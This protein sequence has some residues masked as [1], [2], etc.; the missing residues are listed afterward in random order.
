VTI[1]EVLALEPVG[2]LS[3][4]GR[5]HDRASAR[6]FGGEVAGQAVL[7]A[8]L[9][10]PAERHINNASFYFLLPGDTSIPVEFHVEE[11]RD[12]GAFSTRRVDAVQQGSVILT[13]HASF[14][15]REDGL[16]HQ[17]AH[18]DA[19]PPESLPTVEEL[20]VNDPDNLAW[21]N[22][23]TTALNVD[24]RFPVLPPRV[25]AARGQ[26][27]VPPRQQAW[28]RSRGPVAS[29]DLDQAAAVAYL[30]D[31]LL[32]STAL[33]PHGLTLQGGRLQ[34]ATIH[35]SLWFHHPVRV[36]DWF[37]YDQESRWAGGA[38]ALC[39]GEMF[40]R[41]GRLCATVVQEGLLRLRS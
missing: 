31:A 38:R 24:A 4:R 10:V 17:V 6:T 5:V 26:Q 30:S 8:G 18:L 7:A 22:H 15:R 12:G 19:P 16:E 29:S 1:S 39:T 35:H 32:L 27:K 13:M 9:T 2:A 41:S 34:F 11:V 3:F 36:D 33:G 14:H 23:L 20:F 21:V 25:F 37:F 28:L 40:D